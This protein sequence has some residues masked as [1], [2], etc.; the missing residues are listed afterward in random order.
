[1]SSSVSLHPCFTEAGSLNQ[2]RHSL[3]VIGAGP[4]GAS[5]AI[6]AALAGI[7][8]VMIDT[9]AFP[10][11]HVGETL[12]PGIEPLAEQLGVREQLLA[13]AFERDA[14][15]WVNW[16]GTEEF[17]PYG[18]DKNGQWKGFQAWRSDFDSMLVDQARSLGVNVLQGC[19]ALR[20]IQ[21]DY[22]VT[23]VET[24]QGPLHADMVI[25]AAGGRHFLA[26]HLGIEVKTHSPRLVARYGYDSTSPRLD[27]RLPSIV[28]DDSGWTWRARI[29]LGH[30]H[31]TRLEWNAAGQPSSTTHDKH[32]GADV[33]WRC[34]GEPAG[35]GYFCVGDAACVLDPATAKGVLRGVMAGILA[36][37]RIRQIFEGVC[38]FEAGRES[39]TSW[40]Q[41]W[42]LNEVQML[43]ELYGGLA[44]PPTWLAAVDQ[45]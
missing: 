43:R 33:T 42:F 26:K 44:K 27:H 30:Y 20:P 34:L 35:N 8:C 18:S 11:P 17:Q 29:G 19:R 45:S 31:W 25:D 36:A 39:F 12:H 16:T 23:G 40:L 1:M 4:A 41:D 37:E 2:T 7:E 5:A 10:R 3:V 6:T 14:G 38:S 28:A 24:S 9:Q 15:V 21:S 32:R 22:R 13:A